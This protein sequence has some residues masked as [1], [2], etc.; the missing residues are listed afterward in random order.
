MSIVVNTNMSSVMVQRN[1]YNSTNALTKS[2]QKLSTGLKI[3]SAGDDCAGLSLSEKLKANINSSDVARNNALTGINMLQTAESDLAIVQENLQRMRDLAVQAANGV[4]ASS[5][6]SMLE[7]EFAT[8]MSEIDRIGQSSKFSDLNLLDGSLTSAELQIGTDSSEQ[9]RIDISSAFTEVAASTIGASG[10]NFLD[11]ATI[12]TAASARTAIDI[13]DAAISGLSLRR[14]NIGA[15][16]NRLNSTVSRIDIRKENLAAA[17]S[18]IRDT[19]IATE[20]ANL[21][22]L[23]I[24]QQAG[25]VLLRQANQSTSMALSL[26]Q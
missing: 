7:T 9:S 26:L 6:R 12:T 20:T 22:R 13:V 2:M 4:Y 3:N 16:I 15:T 11:D 10:S 1:I 5:E 17:N 18:V 21:T 24:L 14:S 25:G 19:D 8:R 23:Q